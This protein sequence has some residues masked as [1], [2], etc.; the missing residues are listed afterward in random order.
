MSA[1]ETQVLELLSSIRH[2]IK[3][4][5][6]VCLFALLYYIASKILKSY[7]FKV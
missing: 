6:I 3:I 4:V 7:L 5:A 2:D 1:Y